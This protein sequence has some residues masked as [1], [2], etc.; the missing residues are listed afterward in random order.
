MYEETRKIEGIVKSRMG[1]E[2]LKV[3][4]ELVGTGYSPYT[5]F[6]VVLND[7]LCERK[8]SQGFNLLKI[9]NRFFGKI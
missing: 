2:S 8:K 1:N 5:A 3:Y 9:I 4:R 6:N 7:S